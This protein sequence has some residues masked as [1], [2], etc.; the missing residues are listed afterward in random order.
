MPDSIQSELF[1][2][3]ARQTPS[4]SKKHGRSGSFTDNMRLPV[5]RWFRY[6]AGFSAEW[7]EDVIEQKK[8]KT[9]ELVLD[10][11][12][13]SGT[14]S[15]AAQRV[16]AASLGVENHQFVHRIAW[17]KLHW[18]ENELQL[19][20]E[21]TRLVEAAKTRQKK[22]DI[23]KSDLLSRCFQHESL[24]KLEALKISYLEEAQSKSTESLLWLALTAILRECSPVGTAQ[25]QYIL[26]KKSKAGSKDPYAAFLSKVKTFCAD[27]ADMKASAAGANATVVCSDARHLNNLNKAKG[28]V[29]FI[30]T[31]PPY[32]NNFDYADATRLEMTFWGEI[33]SWGDLHKSVRY[34]LIRSCSQH[35]AADR[36]VLSDV[37]DDPLLEPIKGELTKVCRAL[38]EIRN[39]KGGKKTYHTMVAAYFADLARVWKSLRPLCARGAEACFVVGDSAPYGVYVPVDRWLGELA[40]AAGFRSYQFEKRRDRNLKWKNRKHRVPLKEGNLWVSS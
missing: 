25:W 18:I 30:L 27:M 34:R 13:G 28:R 4:F 32:P 7:A 29:K 1:G 33:E 16:G 5:H 22:I 23:P 8:I 21:A 11:F 35:S 20:D 12:A 9:G 14:T 3:E 36:L 37:L 24:L 38:E 2:T 19:L 6:S 10:P 31:S 26:P 15:I 17:A 39:S 40:L